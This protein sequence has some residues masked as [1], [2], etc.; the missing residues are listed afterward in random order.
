M[1]I[2]KTQNAIE[3]MKHAAENIIDQAG[4]ARTLS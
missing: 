2:P 4:L 3:K 1:N